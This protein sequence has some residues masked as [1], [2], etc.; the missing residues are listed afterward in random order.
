MNH[1]ELRASSSR[2]ELTGTMFALLTPVF[3]DSWYGLLRVLVVGVCAYLMLVCMVRVAGK[4]SLAKMN[5]FDLVVTVAL[6][7]TLSTILLSRDVALAEGLLAMALLLG[8]QTLVAWLSARSQRV[9]Q[10]IKSR[11]SV[12]YE[13]GH[14]DTEKMLEERITKQDVMSAVRSQGL[15]SLEMVERVVLESNGELSVVARSVSH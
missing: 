4:R 13:A 2:L 3:F 6:G 7:S 10:L 14:F 15:P 1:V 11:S 12:L 5:A 8:L 9:N